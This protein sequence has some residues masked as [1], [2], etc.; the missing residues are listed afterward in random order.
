MPPFPLLA[1][2]GSYRACDWDLLR[3]D[4]GRATWLLFFRT[5]FETMARLSAASGYAPAQIDRARRSVH[6]F[7][8]TLER[9]PRALGDRLD[10]LRL[11]ELR[12]GALREA[13]IEDA[14]R[15]QKRAENEAALRLLPERLAALDALD[16]AARRVEL[17]R[18]VFAGNLF[19]LG[20]Q[21]TA[22]RFERAGATPFHAC[23][24]EVRP[25]PWFYDDVEAAGFGARKAVVF[26]DNAGGDVTLGMLPLARELLRA[27]AAVVLAANER[28]SLNDIT[29]TEL[30]DLLDRA[31]VFEDARRAGR[32]RVVSSGSAAPLIDLSKVSSDLCDA[33]EGADLVILEG[34]G[35]ALESNWT[36]RFTCPCW[37]LAIIKDEK[38]AGHH[39]G[40]VYDCVCRV[41]GPDSP[42]AGI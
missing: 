9:D 21:A 34:M 17:F 10:I 13:G 18:G 8:D 1:D 24:A 26:V 27:G 29:A 25:R 39:G 37:R 16:D 33:A 12:D 32:L 31:G 20:A 19:D 35:R 5:H 2:P 28:P 42:P 3:D 38:V 23:L 36:A 6:G 30:D 41:T 4:A 14:C 40:R 7:L 22:D 15:A 11:D